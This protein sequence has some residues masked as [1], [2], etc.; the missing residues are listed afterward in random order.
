MKRRDLFRLGVT[1]AAGGVAGFAAGEPYG[2]RRE[3]HGLRPHRVPGTPEYEFQRRAAEV[4]WLQER[5]TAETVRALKAKFES[6]IL[7]RFRVW[8]LLEKLALCVD[9]SDTNLGCTSQ[10]MHVN[11]ILAAMERDGALDDDLLLTALLH[12]L[13]KVA[14]LQGEAPEHVVC[15]TKPVEACEPGAGLDQALFRF[16]HDE[17]AY[18]R[19]KDLVP[20]HVAWMIRNHSM[21]LG[22]CEPLM[23]AQDREYER[24]YLSR[25]RAYD[26]GFKSKAFLPA[27][28]TLDRFRAFVERWFPQPILF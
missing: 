3:A 6:P 14:M 18:T 26:L 13:G 25:F 21:V 5:Q 12:D 9:P 1:G 2:R 17:I 15:F 10:Y 4:I 16:G 27:Q 28:P 11:Q 23:S 22:E 8:D 19:F 20:E 7:G 24:Q